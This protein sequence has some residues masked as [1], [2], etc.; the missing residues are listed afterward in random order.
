M[1]LQKK[2]REREDNY[3]KRRKAREDGGGGVRAVA[4]ADEEVE[5][6]FAILKRIR[7]AVKY[8]QERNGGHIDLTAA[9]WS[10]SFEP[11][12]FEGVEKYPDSSG[13]KRNAGLDLNSEPD[14]DDLGPVG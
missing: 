1:E 5:E 6:F 14:P 9:M 13:V 3:G 4:V 8:F 7:V 12:D 11:E 10:P 2:E